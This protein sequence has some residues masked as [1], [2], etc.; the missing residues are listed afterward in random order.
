MRKPRLC[1]DCWRREPCTLRLCHM[2][3]P[4]FAESCPAWFAQETIERLKCVVLL[5]VVIVVIVIA[6]K[7][8]ESQGGL[9]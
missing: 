5:G 1:E 7:V 2:D 9:L 3:R 8:L 6:A 4:E